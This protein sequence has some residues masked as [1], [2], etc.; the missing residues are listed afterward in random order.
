MA[1]PLLKLALKA[2]DL[3][4][5]AML[6][7]LLLGAAGVFVLL[8]VASS[9][10]RLAALTPMDYVGLILFTA[11]GLWLLRAALASRATRP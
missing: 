1:L 7:R 8:R 5:V 11:V 10:R 9:L 3:P 4:E 6:G 2:K